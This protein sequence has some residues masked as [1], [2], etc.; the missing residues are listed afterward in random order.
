MEN[1]SENNSD[2]FL[3]ELF[4]NAGHESPSDNFTAGVM[5]KVE[6]EA[7]KSNRLLSPGQWALLAIAFLAVFSLL[8]LVDWSFLGIGLSPDN[9]EEKHYKNFFISLQ[10]T[11]SGF[12]HI[13]NIISGSTVTIAVIAGTGSLFLLDKLLRVMRI[14][15]SA[16]CII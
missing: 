13:F 9:L 4:K 11:F 1:I 15:K 10:S 2:Q 3:K 5:E 14:H 6:I 8:F 12:I 7:S 16:A